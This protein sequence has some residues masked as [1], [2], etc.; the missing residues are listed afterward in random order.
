MQRSAQLEKKLTSFKEAT[1]SGNILEKMFT[2]E[3]ELTEALEANMY[4][5]Q[6][7]R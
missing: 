2:L 5:S 3:M 7:R 4:K 6:L 1:K